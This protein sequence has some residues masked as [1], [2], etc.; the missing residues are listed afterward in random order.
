MLSA[1]S[2]RLSMR[3]F[4][5]RPARRDRRC[6]AGRGRPDGPDVDRQPVR[7]SQIA[8]RHRQVRRPVGAGVAI[9]GR[10]RHR[11]QRDDR[12]ALGPEPGLGADAPETT[13]VPAIIARPAPSP[14]SPPTAMSPRRMPRAGLRPADPRTIDLA[15]GHAALGARRRAAGL[16]PG[17]PPHL[18]RRRRACA[19][20]RTSRRRLHRPAS[21]AGEAGADA[22]DAARGR[23]PGGPARRGRRSPR[24][25]RPAVPRP[26]L[27]P[28][29][30]G[31]DPAASSP[32]GRSQATVLAS[33]PLPPAARAG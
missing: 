29:L 9:R 24:T 17:A 16:G 23:R 5:R 32:R 13:M 33:H 27:D 12:A 18:D 15:A 30:L 4:P 31:A 20:R 19:A 6:S 28:D 22:V 26:V 1:V 10:R 3:E 21:P 7:R 25:D 2:H 11:A 8:E 14:A